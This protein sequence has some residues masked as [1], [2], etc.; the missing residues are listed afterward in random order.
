MSRVERTERARVDVQRIW[1]YV[2]ERNYPAADGLLEDF[3]ESLQLL[4]HHPYMGEAVDALQ[5]GARRLIVKGYQL[6]YLPLDD[7]IRLLRVL[8][9]SRRIQ[10]LIDD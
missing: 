3:E 8:H 2:A 1:V 10:S 7:G 4:K 6:F 9:S 5:P